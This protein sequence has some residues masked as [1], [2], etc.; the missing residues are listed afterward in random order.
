MMYAIYIAEE[1][2]L[3]VSYLLP[4][5]FLEAGSC[6]KK[7]SF[8]LRLFKRGAFSHFLIKDCEASQSKNSFSGKMEL[9]THLF[10]CEAS[11]YS[12]LERVKGPCFT[13]MWLRFSVAI[14]VNRCISEY[15]F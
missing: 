12:R 10:D 3:S 11:Q 7:I 2:R 6:L 13:N 9:F 14:N 4:K 8:S 5:S 1:E 15:A